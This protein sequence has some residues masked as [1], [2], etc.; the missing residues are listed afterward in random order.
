MANGSVYGETW[1][2][3]KVILP[4]T[5]KNIRYTNNSYNRISLNI[6]NKKIFLFKNSQY[7]N[8]DYFDREIISNNILPFSINITKVLEKNEETYFYN[9][10]EAS[11]KGIELA[12]EKLLNDLKG[13][14]K[15][16]F[17]KKLKLY[18]ENSTIVVEVFFKVYEDI[19]DYKNIEVKG[20]MNG[21]D[22]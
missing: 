2:N 20:D 8:E 14:S 17:Q 21:Y 6:F 12:R 18:E 22:F 10:Q 15:I 7:Q 19:T 3:V 1:Y 4:R 11:D 13:D 16:L 9:Y 5:Y